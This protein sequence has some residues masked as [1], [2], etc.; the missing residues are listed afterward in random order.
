MDFILSV[1]KSWCNCFVPHDR[2]LHDPRHQVDSYSKFDV[3]IL[4][5]NYFCTWSDKTNL[6]IGINTFLKKQNY[7]DYIKTKENPNSYFEKTKHNEF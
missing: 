3:L 1:S 4:I 2:N 5:Q 6:N 7:V